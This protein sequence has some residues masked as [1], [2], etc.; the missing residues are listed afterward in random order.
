MESLRWN[1]GGYDYLDPCLPLLR[2]EVFFGVTTLGGYP[3][4]QLLVG[5]PAGPLPLTFID[6][7]NSLAPPVGGTLMNM[8]Y[9][10]DHII[11]LNLP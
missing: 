4:R 8:P 6:Q 9:V 7:S 10:S 2:Q 11:N 3:A 1:A 5:G